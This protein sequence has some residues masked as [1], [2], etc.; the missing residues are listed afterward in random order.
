MLEEQRMKKEDKLVS[1]IT[2]EAN[3]NNG[4]LFILMRQIKKL[5]R[6]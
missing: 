6:D 5:Q 2:T 4:K 1:G 3:I